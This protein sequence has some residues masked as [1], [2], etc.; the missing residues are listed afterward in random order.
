MRQGGIG[1]AANGLFTAMATDAM[2]MELLPPV[3]V[4]G[5]AI[6]PTAMAISNLEVEEP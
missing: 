6:A 1:G 3:A 4:G 2:W 5:A